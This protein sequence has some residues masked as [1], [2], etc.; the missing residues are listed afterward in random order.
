M[1]DRNS[2]QCCL[3]NAI[4][5][6]YVLQY[7]SNQLQRSHVAT[8]HCRCLFVYC[9]C[10]INVDPRDVSLDSKDLCAKDVTLLLVLVLNDSY[11]RQHADETSTEPTHWYNNNNCISNSGNSILRCARLRCTIILRYKK[12]L[13]RKS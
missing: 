6:N 5:N 10:I 4:Y 13:F 12:V 3:D 9:L 7:R 1:P 11:Q 8:C 2:F